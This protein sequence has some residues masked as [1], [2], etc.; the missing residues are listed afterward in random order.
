LNHGLPELT[1]C[2]GFAKKRY[3]EFFSNPE[4]CPASKSAT[5]ATAMPKTTFGELS[6]G[7]ANNFDFLRVCLAILVIYSH[8]YPLTG[9]A[10]DPFAWLSN[11]QVTLGGLAVFGFFTISGFL[12]A[13]SWERSRGLADYAK[14]RALRIYPGFVVAVLFC[15]FVVGPLGAADRSTYFHSGQTYRFFEALCLRPI[16]VLPGV[17][18][19]LP[20]SADVN[21]SLWT[22]RWE[23]VCYFLLAL[24]G[25]VGGLRRRGWVLAVFAGVYFITHICDFSRVTTLYL[26]SLDNSPELLDFFLAGAAFYVWRDRIPHSRVLMLAS[27]L[28]VAATMWGGL[29]W[30]LPIFG[31]YALFYATFE[32]STKLQNFAERA[33]GDLSY[34]LYLYAFPVQQLVVQYTH[35]INPLPVF[36]LAFAITLVLAAASWHFVEA[37]CLRFKSKTAAKG[38]RRETL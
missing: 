38:E 14:K 8:S 3:R 1:G 29:R 7:R 33:H 15:V 26:G 31:V 35:W 13:G 12:V 24:L 16:S 27:L 2:G 21:G 23:I 34:G 19:N 36:L 4:R 25:A 37:P 17:F 6:R 10:T 20:H 28:M 18:L 11:N 9:A 5:R 30:T 22:I 32:P